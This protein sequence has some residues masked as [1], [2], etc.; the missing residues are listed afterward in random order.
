MTASSPI[1]IGS[2]IVVVGAGTMGRGIAL[3]A[4]ASGLHVHVVD[5]NAEVLAGAADFIAGRVESLSTRLGA[6]AGRTSYGRDLGAALRDTAQRENGAPVAAVIEAVPEQAALKCQIFATMA[7]SA[8]PATLLASNTSTMS[9]ADLAGAA[10]DS[11]RVIG[12]HFFNPAH[13]M[14]LVEVVTAPTTGDAARADALQ[15]CRILH[16]DAI[17][18][19]DAPGF[20]TSRLG[21]LLGNEAMR[22]VADGIASA[23]DV[24]KAMRLG[25]NHPM[26]PLELADLV[27]LDARLNNLRSVTARMGRPEFEPPQILV[28][29]VAAGKLGRKSGEGFYRYDDEGHIDAAAPA[30]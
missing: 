22:I 9:I 2:R 18:V 30:T 23:A 17:V 25:Y 14:Q 13:R 10:G 11:D 21:L 24:D 5:P 8:D 28:D 16:K 29:L 7:E 1:E 3:A 20:V 4:A 26:G 6:P 15:L 12:M 27:G 19:A